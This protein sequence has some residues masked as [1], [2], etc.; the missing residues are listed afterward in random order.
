M[1]HR[2]PLSF[3]HSFT[4]ILMQRGVSCKNCLE[5]SDFVKRVKETEHLDL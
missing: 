3:I 2:L 5:K 4:Q 1:I